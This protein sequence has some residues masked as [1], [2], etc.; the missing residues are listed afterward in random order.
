M[1]LP[2]G[3][4]L[5]QMDAVEKE[6]RSRDNFVDKFP[7]NPFKPWCKFFINEFFDRLASAPGAHVDIDG[8]RNYA[9]DEGRRSSRQSYNPTGESP[10]VSIAHIGHVV[11]PQPGAGNQLGLAWCKRPSCH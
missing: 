1:D 7:K 8:A 5:R 2:K 3:T 10:V 6:N 11:I 9:R 4:I